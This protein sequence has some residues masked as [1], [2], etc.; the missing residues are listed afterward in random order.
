MVKNERT[1][2]ITNPELIDRVIGDIQKGLA[3]KLPWLD[4]AFGKAQRL[5]KIINNKRY[6]T[7]N[8]YAG[9]KPSGEYN[10][11][12]VSPDAK[13]GNFSFFQIDDPQIMDWEPNIRGK[14]DAPF[15]LIFWFDMRKVRPGDESRNTEAV[16]AEILKVL[17][18]GIWVKSGRI[19][20]NKIYEQA[21]NIYK[22]Y[23]LD[24]VDNQFLMHP[25]AGMR[26]DGILTINESC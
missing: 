25:Y 26:F 7:P 18:G 22:G 11:L 8:V 20:I 1:P 9:K 24:E 14:I 10:Y 15:G 23:T 21:E 19:V 4:Y 13:I 16:K 6:Y 3:D 17:N 2:I 12:G 5:V